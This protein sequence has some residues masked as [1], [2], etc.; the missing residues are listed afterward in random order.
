MLIALNVVLSILTPFKLAN[1]KFTFEAFPILVAGILLGPIDGLIVGGVG[2]LIYQLLFSGYG[3]MPTTI[4]WIIPHAFSGFLVGLYSKKHNYELTKKQTIFI[5]I[6]SSL[7]VTTLN[8][9]ALYVDSKVY[10]YYSFAFVF[11]SI[12]FKVISGIVLAIIYS[13]I[14]PI[15]IK[16]LKNK[17]GLKIRWID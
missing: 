12:V 15:L 10:G 8:T 13:T 5:A 9:V 6:V 14:I 16:Y 4:L 3:L 17:L 1:F 2:S 7:V 11:G